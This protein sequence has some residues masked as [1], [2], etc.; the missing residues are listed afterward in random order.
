VILSDWNPRYVI[1]AELQ[2][3]LPWEQLAHD[4]KYWSGGCMAGFTIWIMRASL[5]FEKKKGEDGCVL[6]RQEEFTE[7]LRTF[8]VQK[9]EE[10]VDEAQG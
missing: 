4:Q 9:N 5:A 3:R 6:W 10:V 2:G 8:E 7:F 1:Y